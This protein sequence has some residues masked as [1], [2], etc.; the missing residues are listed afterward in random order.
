MANPRVFISS[1]CYDLKYIR[2]NLKYFIKT[3]GYEPVLSEDGAVFYD[4]NSHTHDSCIAEVLNCQI[5]VLIIGGRYGGKFKDNEYSITNAEY[6]EA[7]NKKIPIF[8]LVDNSVYN[9][10][11]VYIDNKKNNKENLNN[12]RFPSVDN[13]KIFEFIDEVRSQTINNS[14]VSFKDFSD[15]ENYLRQQWSA[16]MYSFLT[17]DNEEKRVH[18]TLSV[19]TDINTKI[20]MLTKQILNSVGTDNAKLEAKFYEMMMS[21]NAIQDLTFFNIQPTPTTIM[22]HS[23]FRICVKSFETELDFK[24]KID[25]NEV[26]FSLSTDGTMSRARFERNAKLY[27]QLRKDMLDMLNDYGIKPEDFVSTLK[28][29]LNKNIE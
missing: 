23:S 29:N 18:N 20:E 4:P 16:M 14:L 7:V 13:I 6:K 1:T 19:I 22:L 5:F 2:E 26:G 8:T 17:R 28:V 21:N 11:H 15:I 25:E 9:E 10:H 27:K 24:F 3:I 12:I